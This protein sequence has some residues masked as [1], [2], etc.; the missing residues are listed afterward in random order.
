MRRRPRGFLRPP[1]RRE[2]VLLTTVALLAAS[3]TLLAGH[4]AQASLGFEPESLNGSGNNQANP[5]W[6]Q[7]GTNYIRVAPARY[8][9]GH[10][11]MV[12]GP[13]VR[14]VS[15]RVFQDLGQNVFSEHRVTQWGWTWGQFLDHTFGLAADGTDAANI[16]FDATDPME[17]FT[18]T[19]GV[20]P[21]TRTKAAPGTGVTNPRQQINTVNS[22]LDAW[23]VYGG[24]ND[25]LEW[26]RQGP[27]DG[28]LADNS[29]NLMLPGGY[30]PRRDSRGDPAH[31]P[32]MA[33]DGR[34]L[35]QPD[36]AAVAGDVRANENIG[37]TATHTLFAREHNR[38]VGLLPS[39]LTNEQK[40]QLARRIV[41]AEQQYVTFN[42]FLPA[43]GVSLPMYTG[44]QPSVRTSLSDEFAT[45]GYRAHSQVHGEF[46]LETDAGRYSAATLA[47]LKAEG[48]EVTP[49]D[50][51][52]GLTLAVPL[53]V[54][55]FNPDLVPMLQLGPLLQ[56]IGGESQYNNDEQIDDALRSVLFQVPVS[57]N[58]Q[59]FDNP[60]LPKCFTGVVDLGAI[61]IQ[62]GR[63]HGMPSYNQLRQAYGLP[64]KTSFKDITGESSEDFPSD[65]LLTPGHEIDDPNSL[66]YTKLS[67]IDGTPVP[68]PDTA[69]NAAT[70]AVRRTPLAARLKAVYG[71]VDNV[72][73][74]VGLVAEKHVTGTELGELQV[75]MWTR[76]FQ[77]LRDGDRFFYGND[78]ELAVIAQQY[79]IDY[80][81]SLAQIIAANTEIPLADLN[82]NVFVT[83]DDDLPPAACTVTY[84]VDSSWTG[85][86]QVSLAITNNG[87]KPL[88]GWTVRW[89]FAGG[90]TIAQLWNGTASQSGSRVTVTNPSWNAVIPPGGTVTDVGF[91]GRWD[92]VTNASPPW[93]TLNNARCART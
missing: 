20:I 90:Q 50:T 14:Y 84:H 2:V 23:P 85:Q 26:L 51:G 70:R 41:I 92:N 65:P 79:G 78:P 6:G 54:A 25:R 30:L 13:N 32:V 82:D 11:A 38:L 80:R 3:V 37:L 49:A 36:R 7:A 52:T 28:N 73:A 35:G 87:T 29:A 89:R 91:I 15:N 21:F 4:G 86:Y 48:V 71:S 22:Y 74:F 69:N 64:P 12:A 46:E 33:T 55:F 18:D 83:A 31:A 58:P 76:Q 40:F 72:D 61:D 39:S 62:R 44:Y 42:E 66:D 5:T 19:L 24:T 67:N 27:V 1:R 16:P 34:L 81:H 75:A 17:K 77:A 88:N 45:V 68:L 43:M 9:D 60:S 57:G 59:C 10:S 93:I 47:A 53:N 63:D 56:A 8:A